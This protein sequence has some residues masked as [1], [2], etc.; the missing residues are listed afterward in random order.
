M[1][2]LPSEVRSEGRIKKHEWS[3]TVHQVLHVISSVFLDILEI[4]LT[5]IRLNPPRLLIS[6]A[7]QY[8][9]ML[10]AAAFR[11]FVNSYSNE[12]VQ[13]TEEL[14]SIS[15]A[16]LTLLD[17]SCDACTKIAGLFSPRD[18]IEGF[19]GLVSVM[20][21]IVS[22]LTLAQ[23]IPAIHIIGVVIQA[24]GF[25]VVCHSLI[26]HRFEPIQQEKYI[27]LGMDATRAGIIFACLS[28]VLRCLNLTMTQAVSS[29]VHFTASSFCKGT[30][31]WGL[32]MTSA[33]HLLL[34]VAG[35]EKLIILQSQSQVSTLIIVFI[36]VGAFKQY[37]CFWLVIHT[38]A[39]E[40]SQVLIFS[41]VLMFIVRRIVYREDGATF[42]Y[43]KFPLIGMI[44]TFTGFGML[45]VSS[46][47]VR[48]LQLDDSDHA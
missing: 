2:L 13:T 18:E 10:L 17:I 26:D 33:Y 6:Q 41:K 9:G 24:I 27:V 42:G 3:I 16:T 28:H 32:L 45:S 14:P 8:L 40:Y 47:G 7:F 12:Q 25:G 37:T 19:Y 5:L 23:P 11:S 38:S 15:A 35:E 4:R 39:M 43:M 30:G 22:H 20:Q 48:T 29:S 21:T 34:Y 44:I 31:L 46:I 1:E 36:I